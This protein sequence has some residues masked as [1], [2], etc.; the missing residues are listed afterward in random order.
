MLDDSYHELKRSAAPGDRRRDVARVRGEGLGGTQRPTCHRRVH[1]GTYRA[2][3]SKRARIPKADG[4]QRLLGIASLE[5]KIVQQAVKTVLEQIYEEDFVGFSYG[6]RPGRGCQNALD[7]LWMGIMH[8]K[9]NWVLDADIRGFFDNIDHEWM[10]KFLEHSSRRSTDAARLIRKWL[11]GGG[12]RRTANGRRTDGRHAARIGGS[13]RF[14]RT[15]SCTTYLDL[16]AHRLAEST[17][18]ADRRNHRSLCRRFRH[19]FSI[20]SIR[21]RTIPTRVGNSVWKSSDFNFTRT[22]PG[23]SS[24]AAMRSSD[25]RN[26]AEGKPEDVRLLGLHAYLRETRDGAFTVEANSR[27]PSACAATLA[28]PIKGCVLAGCDGFPAAGGGRMA[29]FRGLAARM[30]PI[31]RGAG[32][33]SAAWTQFRNQVKRLWRRTSSRDAADKGRKWTWQQFAPRGQL[34]GCPK[35]EYFNPIPISD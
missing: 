28:R 27:P 5:D 13:R 26:R 16:W 31:P 2:Q 33:L 10:L 18:H 19:G 6:F 32:K 8:G 15:C 29:S 34:L 9:V 24:S 14:W 4:R 25:A 35:R 23:S 21:R 30:V 11:K 1:D 20:A 3:P 7:A 12:I 17:T 22:R